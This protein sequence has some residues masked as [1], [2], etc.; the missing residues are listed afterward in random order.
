MV[1]A[2]VKYAEG[3]TVSPGSGI[4]CSSDVAP[5]FMSHGCSPSKKTAQSAAKT[6]STG[7]GRQR[8]RLS[9]ARCLRTVDMVDLLSAEQR[10][11]VCP[12][13]TH[14]IVDAGCGKGCGR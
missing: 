8:S 7:K 1:M 2:R 11:A 6:S 3:A 10:A 5:Q 4:A 13:P 14:M 9:A 12:A